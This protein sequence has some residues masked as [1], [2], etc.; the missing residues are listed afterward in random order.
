M[1]HSYQYSL[2]AIIFGQS[3]AFDSIKGVKFS[4][5][6]LCTPSLPWEWN[7]LPTSC[8]VTIAFPFDHYYSMFELVS[9]VAYATHL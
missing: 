9:L 4:P 2:S 1:T 3:G 8:Y 7:V 6:S 5:R